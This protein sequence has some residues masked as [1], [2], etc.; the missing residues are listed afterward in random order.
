MLDVS[1]FILEVWAKRY[2]VIYNIILVINNIYVWQSYSLVGC[3]P[4]K[5][6]GDGL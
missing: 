6:R 3:H 1:Q 2:F 4:M 5:K